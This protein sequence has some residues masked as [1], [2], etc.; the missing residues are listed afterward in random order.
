MILGHKTLTNSAGR[1]NRLYEPN[2]PA[3]EDDLNRIYDPA[4]LKERL[5]KQIIKP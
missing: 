3:E 5:P 2:K 4:N 1:L